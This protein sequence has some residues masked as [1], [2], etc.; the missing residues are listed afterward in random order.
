MFTTG[1]GKHEYF[2]C[3]FFYPGK[4]PLPV[5]SIKFV[6]MKTNPSR[7]FCV[8]ITI[9]FSA[10]FIGLTAIAQEK[11]NFPYFEYSASKKA[12]TETGIYKAVFDNETSIASAVAFSGR[13]VLPSLLINPLTDKNFFLIQVESVMNEL[14]SM[15]IVE[16]SGK[17]V[18]YE[19]L[20]LIAGVNNISTSSLENLPP[21]KYQVFIKKKGD[22]YS[23]SVNIK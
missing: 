6:T 4:N 8:H 15:I 18:K 17:I 12:A 5:E 7:H 13:S 20:F 21:G 9:L 22:I 16:R 1:F 14:A 11:I 3:L 2:K 23:Q 19:E 10:L